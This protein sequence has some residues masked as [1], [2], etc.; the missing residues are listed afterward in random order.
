[1]RSAK[2]KE[3]WRIDANTAI[4]YADSNGIEHFRVAMEEYIAATYDIRECGKN[5]QWGD[6]DV[7]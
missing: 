1:M 3:E 7:S 4:S 5:F 2:A 6:D